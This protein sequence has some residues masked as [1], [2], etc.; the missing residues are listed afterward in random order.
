MSMVRPRWATASGGTFFS[1]SAFAK[2]NS[3]GS[4][5]MGAAR[6]ETCRTPPYCGRVSAI[7]ATAAIIMMLLITSDRQSKRFIG[8]CLLISRHHDCRVALRLCPQCSNNPV[9]REIDSRTHRDRIAIGKLIRAYKIARFFSG[10]C[11][12]HL[13]AGAARGLHARQIAAPAEL[14]AL[15]TDA[16]DHMHATIR[17]GEQPQQVL[18]AR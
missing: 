11:G 18:L 13:P 9:A 16:V 10:T 6:I 12:Q 7:A 3:A 15:V 2:S 8:S 4:S 17:G 5:D 14:E 1:G